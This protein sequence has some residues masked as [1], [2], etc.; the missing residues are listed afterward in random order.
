MTQIDDIVREIVI[1]ARRETVF[2]FFT[3][4]GHWA[5]WWGKGS[6]V[7][8]KPGGAVLIAHPGDV[9]ASGVVKEIVPLE[10][11][12]FSYGYE[13][14]GRP[15]APGGSTVIVTLADAPGGTK[16]TLRHTGLPDLETAREHEQGWRYQM[17]VLSKAATQVEHA[18]ANERADRWF[19]LWGEGDPAKRKAAFGEMTDDVMFHDQYSALFGKDDVDAQCAAAAI[20]MPGVRLFRVGNAVASHGS[21]LVRW[22]ARSADK[23]FGTGTNLFDFAPDG[24]IRRVVGFWGA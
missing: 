24:R 12:V 4:S 9:R 19:A 11:F 16:V 3:D 6:T 13:G 1:N 2:A 10:R 18:A 21:A 8:P 5:S 20:H 14:E 17:S 15:I 23:T 22:E 7:D